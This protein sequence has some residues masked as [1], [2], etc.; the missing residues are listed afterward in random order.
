MADDKVRI[1][2]EMAVNDN[3]DGLTTLLMYIT[4]QQF[5]ALDINLTRIRIKHD[6]LT[7]V[8]KLDKF[9]ELVKGE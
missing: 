4:K 6:G 1:S 8:Y 2:L 5:D 9:Y 7:K 3:G